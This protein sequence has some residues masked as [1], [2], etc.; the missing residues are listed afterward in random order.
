MFY[1][2]GGIDYSVS[3][4]ITI[5]FWKNVL[6]GINLFKVHE[7]RSHYFIS[8]CLYLYWSTIMEGRKIIH[9]DMDAFYAAVEQ[10]DNPDLRGKAIAIGSAKGRGVVATASYEARKY[11]IHSAM[12]S[13]TAKRRCPH[14]IFVHGNLE[15]YRKVSEQIRTI[16]FDYTDEVEPLSLDEAYLDVTENKKGNPS[17]TLI[18]KEIKQRI[19]DTT[20]LRASAGVS[21][22]KFLAKIASDYDKPDGLFVITPEEAEPFIESLKVEKFFGIGKVTAEKMHKMGIF[23][24]KDLKKL[25]LHR[26]TQT[27]G[28]AGNYYYQIARGIDSRVV[29]PH[30]ERKSVGGENTFETDITQLPEMEQR[31]EIIGKK[32]WERIKKTGKYGRTLTLKIKFADFNQITRSKTLLEPIIDYT[33]FWEHAVELLHESFE[34]TFRVRLLGLSVSNFL[35]EEQ[36]AVQLVIDFDKPKS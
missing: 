7:N 31:L 27:F 26:L 15:K 4:L 34:A 22:N 9:I 29:N 17:G 18:A 19:F 23:F 8:R 24:G 16:F 3:H 2:V 5:C 35:T 1:F 10:R 28:K 20:Q 14:L 33:T 21:Y 6:S 12:P 32:V 13:A 30:R 36:E 25:S 11:G